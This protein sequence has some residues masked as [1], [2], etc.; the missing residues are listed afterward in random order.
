MIPVE[1]SENIFIQH[2]KNK[3]EVKILKRVIA[4]PLEMNFENNKKKKMQHD[5]NYDKNVSNLIEYVQT[6]ES[7]VPS[8]LIEYVQTDESTVPSNLIEYVI[9]DEPTVPNQQML[10]GD[11]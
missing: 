10:Q 3:G 7:T 8:N 1:N 9:T 11:C 6:D 4:S 2:G 5:S